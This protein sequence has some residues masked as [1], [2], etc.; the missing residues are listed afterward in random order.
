MAPAEKK[1][2]AQNVPAHQDRSAKGFCQHHGIIFWQHDENQG[3]QAFAA[4]RQKR[5][6]TQ[7]A[8]HVRRRRIQKSPWTAFDALAH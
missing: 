7:Q 8:T 6:R 2:S 4:N 1:C 3:L 5:S